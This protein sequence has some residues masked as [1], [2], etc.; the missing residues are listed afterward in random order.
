MD[1]RDQII[2]RHAPFYVMPR[3]GDPEPMPRNS[4]RYIAAEDGLWLQLH[5]PW[6]HTQH[7]IAPSELQLP[8]GPVSPNTQYTFDREELLAIIRMFIQ[9]ARDARPNE[10]AAWAIWDANDNRLHY[11]PLT[12]DHASPGSISYQCPVLNDYE[13]LAIDLH[14]HG[15]LPAFWSGTDDADDAGEVKLSVVVGQVNDT[16]PAVRIRLCLLGLFIDLESPL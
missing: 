7:P 5:R 11:R 15:D 1:P 14:S 8:Y 16:L 4:H 9:D 2:L 6:L 12:P 3:F 13:S 10:A